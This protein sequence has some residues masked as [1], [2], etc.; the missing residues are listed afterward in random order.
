[1]ESKGR[2][3]KNEKKILMIVLGSLCFIA[4]VLIVIILVVANLPKNSSDSDTAVENET[5]VEETAPDYAQIAASHEEYLK[6]IESINEALNTEALNGLDK[7]L[8]TYQQYID[9]AENEY[10]KDMLRVD[11]YSV[12]KNFDID[13]VRGDEVINGLLE[14]DASLKNINA[15]VA[16]V[17]AATYYERVDLAQ[18]YRNIL[19]DRQAG[20]GIDLEMET[21]G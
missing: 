5:V 19:N 9:S 18:Q 7:V 12:I 3:R 2:E 15:A 16:V 10:V 6:V 11:Y 13:K 14:I 21:E 4:V 20:A 8:E 17:N 1:M